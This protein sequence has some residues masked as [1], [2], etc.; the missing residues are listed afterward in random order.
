MQIDYDE[1]LL[2]VQVAYLDK[3]NQL[4]E[5]VANSY[6]TDTYET[7]WY[8]QDTRGERVARLGKEFGRIA[9]ILYHLQ[10]LGKSKNRQTN[11]TWWFN[12]DWFNEDGEEE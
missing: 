6:P 11:F 10:A 7:E 12:E 5:L 2:M 4:Q 9:N 3:K 8:H 1:L